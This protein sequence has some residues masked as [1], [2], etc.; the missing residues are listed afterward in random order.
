MGLAAE[1][2]SKV[3]RASGPRLLLVPQALLA[4]QYGADDTSEVW[5]HHFHEAALILGKR[6]RR[7]R[8]GGEDAENAIAV[9]QRSTDRTSELHAAIVQIEC[10]VGV[11]NH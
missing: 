7:G 5:R 9:H 10:G 6:P 3:A 11:R 1:D 8:V 4:T 2:D